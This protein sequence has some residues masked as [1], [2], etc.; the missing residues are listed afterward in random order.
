MDSVL[1]IIELNSLAVYEDELTD[2]SVKQLSDRR[3][4]LRL[5]LMEMEGGTWHGQA[6]PTA[7]YDVVRFS[8]I[9]LDC[10]LDSIVV[11][12]REEFSWWRGKIKTIDTF[13]QAQSVVPTFTLSLIHPSNTATQLSWSW[14]RFYYPG[15]LL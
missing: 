3:D 2:D 4:R 15:V 11:E 13:F 14:A 7:E 10:L 12:D 8:L 5:W 9:R 1:A 6:P